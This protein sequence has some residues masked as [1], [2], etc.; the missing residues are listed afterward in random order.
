M[1]HDDQGHESKLKAGDFIDAA[2]ESRFFVGH[3]FGILEL[4]SGSTFHKLSKLDED[5]SDIGQLASQSTKRCS[6]KRKSC[7]ASIQRTRIARRDSGF[8]HNVECQTMPHR[9]LPCC[10]YF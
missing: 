6:M 7:P 9:V 2:F 3:R 1:T 4:G 10:H 8:T 5:L